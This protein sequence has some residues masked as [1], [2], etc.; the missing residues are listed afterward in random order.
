MHSNSMLLLSSPSPSVSATH[1]RS[2]SGSHSLSQLLSSFLG[3]ELDTLDAF[4]LHRPAHDDD[5]DWDI[6]LSLPAAASPLPSRSAT[7][8][9]HAWGA[10]GVSSRLCA[11]VAIASVDVFR[12]GALD[13]AF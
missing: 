11:N 1:T 6:A 3:L 7:P 5:V 9:H 12:L 13:I 10:Q 2:A 8:K 4:E